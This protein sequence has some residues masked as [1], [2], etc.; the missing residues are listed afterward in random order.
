[1]LGNWDRDPDRYGR[2]REI[3]SGFLRSLYGEEISAETLD[4]WMNVPENARDARRDGDARGF[5]RKVRRSRNGWPRGYAC[6]KTS[7]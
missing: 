2:M 6:W 7:G 5:R 1:M 3:V 4:T